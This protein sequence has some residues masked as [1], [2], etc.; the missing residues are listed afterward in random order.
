M[1]SIGCNDCNEMMRP[2]QCL[3]PCCFTSVLGTLHAA[4]RL[5]PAGSSMTVAG[6]CSVAPHCALTA[7]R[8][9]A[10]L[11]PPPRGAFFPPTVPH[12][13][14]TA[15]T[16]CRMLAWACQHLGPLARR[17]QRMLP[18]W[19]KLCPSCS[20]WELILE[21]PQPA[22]RRTKQPKTGCMACW[23]PLLRSVPP[24]GACLLL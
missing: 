7:C 20:C 2:H 17:S 4:Y 13:C 15:C 5:H 8:A 14:L 10:C 12:L 11:P 9:A 21:P 18:C 6:S 23:K 22:G 3:Q 24:P 19:S 16:A 1:D